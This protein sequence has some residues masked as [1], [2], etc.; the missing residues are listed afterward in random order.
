MPWHFSA[1]TFLSG[2]AARVG[3]RCS[4]NRC[5]REEGKRQIEIRTGE[6]NEEEVEECRGQSPIVGAHSDRDYV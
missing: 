4:I 5:G 1:L 6:V 2:D 3:V